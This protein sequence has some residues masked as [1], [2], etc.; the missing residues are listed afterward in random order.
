MKGKIREKWWK[1][2]KKEA[3]ICEQGERCRIYRDRGKNISSGRQE[4]QY[5]ER[6]AGFLEMKGKILVLVDK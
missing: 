2:G 1:S 6:F 5:Q 3:E 4:S